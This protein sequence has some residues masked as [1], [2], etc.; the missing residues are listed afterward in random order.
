M[1]P[2]CLPVVTYLLTNQS[3]VLC[4]DVDFYPIYSQLVF[5]FAVGR[6]WF[7]FFVVVVFLLRLIRRSWLRL[8]LYTDLR[9]IRI[10]CRLGGAVGKHRICFKQD[11]VMFLLL[12]LDSS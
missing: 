6:L 9:C 4:L 12:S 7:F 1:D 10:N 8:P 2:A 3:I 11:W 5:F